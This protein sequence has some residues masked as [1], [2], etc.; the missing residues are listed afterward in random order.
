[1]RTSRKIWLTFAVL[2]CIILLSACHGNSEPVEGVR[3]TPEVLESVSLSL[4]ENAS[5]SFAT[6]QTDTDAFEATVYEIVY[7][8]ESGSVYHITDL[9]GSLKH[10]TEIMHG[11]VDEAIAAKKERPCKSCAG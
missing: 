9:C 10:S 8:T 6:V 4:A 1:M 7:W 5:T 11:S 2:C 3:I